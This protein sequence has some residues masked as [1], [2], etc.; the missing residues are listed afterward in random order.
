MSTRFIGVALRWEWR[1]FEWSLP[2]THGLSTTSERSWSCNLLIWLNTTHY[3]Q[4]ALNTFANI[5]RRMTLLKNLTKLPFIDYKCKEVTDGGWV[6]VKK[7]S[8]KGHTSASHMGIVG[9]LR[10]VSECLHWHGLGPKSKISYV[11]HQ[12]ER[13]HGYRSVPL[14]LIEAIWSVFWEPVDPLDS[15]MPLCHPQDERSVPQLRN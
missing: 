2:A 5:P 14:Q 9:C 11:H 13:Q 4:L 1:T 8:W 12:K 7:I 6:V 3:L 10:R 15:T